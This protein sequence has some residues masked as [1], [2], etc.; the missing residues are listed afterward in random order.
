MLKDSVHEFFNREYPPHVVREMDAKEQYPDKL[1]KQAAE[2]GWT[3]LPFPEEYGGAG[4][5][6][7]DLAVL[8]EAASWH[9]IGAA[10]V[11]NR[12]VIFGGLSILTYGSEEHKRRFIPEIIK[13]DITFS[14]GL[15]EPD[16][17]SDALNLRTT[18][19]RDGNEWV[20]NG[21]KMFC[22]GA[23]VADYI[24]VVAITNP[25]VPR[26]NGLSIF[27]VDPSL[28]GVSVRRIPV[29]GW[30]T[31]GTCEVNLVDVRVP[32]DMVLGN[33]NEGW[34]NIRSTLGHSRSNLSAIATGAAQRVVDD[35]VAYAQQRIQ[36]DQPIGSFQAIQ[37]MLADMQTQ[38]DAA[39]LMAYRAAYLVSQGAKCTRETAMAKLYCTETWAKVA[40]MGMQIMGG[41]GYSMEFDMQRHFRDSRLPVVGEGSSQIQRNII[42]RTMG[43]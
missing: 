11:I 32:A 29:L 26:R 14:L 3:A 21:T 27:L 6:A 30:R 7:V 31:T 37:H 38:V 5:T 8:L 16:A 20:L 13:G 41:Y 4:A 15:T 22:S 36:F 17:G 25:D 24:L 33:L 28:P 43:L 18:A 12:S 40:T 39:R 10:S 34:R 35:A 19:V 1:L 9:M 23:D 2:L 42:A